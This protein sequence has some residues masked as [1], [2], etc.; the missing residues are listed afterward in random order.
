MKHTCAKF[1]VISVNLGNIGILDHFEIILPFLNVEV[2][3]SISFSDN[4]NYSHFYRNKT[5]S[6]NLIFFLISDCYFHSL[7]FLR[8]TNR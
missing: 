4:Y 2:I 7:L 6:S 8:R 3:V 5:T 1:K